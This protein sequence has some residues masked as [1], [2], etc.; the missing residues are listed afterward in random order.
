MVPLFFFL[1]GLQSP[2]FSLLLLA[3]VLFLLYLNST[4]NSAPRGVFVDTNSVPV[5]F[6][7][8]AEVFPYFPT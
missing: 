1:L 4:A 8:L 2:L 3:F 5:D 7:E 6:N